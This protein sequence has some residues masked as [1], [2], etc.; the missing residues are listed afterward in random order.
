MRYCTH[1][2]CLNH[3]SIK[4][5]RLYQMFCKQYK[6][7]LLYLYFETI[8]ASSGNFHSSNHVSHLTMTLH[9]IINHSQVLPFFLWG[10]KKKT[11]VQ[12]NITA[13][14]NYFVCCC[15][16]SWLQFPHVTKTMYSFKM[17]GN[18][19]SDTTSYSKIWILKN[20]AMKTS[21]LTLF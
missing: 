12:P 14:L 11:V 7:S 6:A 19:P 18:K 10:A 16:H 17:P 8:S 20:T 15:C 3:T 21:N 1:C 4:N 9:I 5:K 2:Y 13:C